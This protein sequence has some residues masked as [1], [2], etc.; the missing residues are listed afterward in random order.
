MPS[1]AARRRIS[2][3]EGIKQLTVGF[4]GQ[5]DRDTWG[6]GSDG[7]LL[8]LIN[9]SQRLLADLF[10]TETSPTLD[11][12]S[13]GEGSAVDASTWDTEQFGIEGCARARALK[14][15]AYE[16][17]PNH[18]TIGRLAHELDDLLGK[19]KTQADPR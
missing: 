7:G 19:L 18:L 8:G 6:D 4:T 5:I 9:R 3:T 14:E 13:A 10:D 17:R 12:A 16:P 2:L 11:P 15:Q 1:G